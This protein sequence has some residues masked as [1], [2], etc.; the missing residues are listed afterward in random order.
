MATQ[1]TL[2]PSPTP[3]DIEMTEDEFSNS[4]RDLISWFAVFGPEANS[5]AR[6]MQDNAAIAASAVASLANLEWVSGT[7]YAAGNVR[8]SKIDFL[9]YRRKTNGAGTTDPRNDP[10]NWSV[11]VS[12]TQGGADTT[13]SASNIT[14]TSTNGRLQSISMTAA[15][16]KVTLPAATALEKGIPIFVFKNAGAYRFAIVNNSGVFLGYVDPG[17]VVSAGCSDTS[18]AAGVWAIIGSVGKLY[19]DNTQETVNAVVSHHICCAMLTATKAVVGYRNYSTGFLEAVI[20]NYGSASGTPIVLNSESS[21]NISITAQSASQAT[22][23]YSPVSNATIKGYVLDISS[24]TITP[25]SVQTIHTSANVSFKATSITTI[26]TTKLL[27]AYLGGVNSL[28]ERII[29][30]SGTTLTP[31][32][33]VQADSG[34]ATTTQYV[35]VKGL[36]NTK[37][38]VSYLSDTGIA[39]RLQAITGSTPSATGSVLSLLLPGSLMLAQFGFCVMSASRLVII[40]SIDRTRGDVMVFLVDIS[41]NTPVLLY[42][43]NLTIDF[44]RTETQI[45]AAKI[46]TN[47]VYMTYT[48]AYSGGVDSLIITV[49]SD[50]RILFSDVTENVLF[51]N[52][53][54]PNGTISN[55]FPDCEPLDS[56]HVLQLSRNAAGNLISKTLEIAPQ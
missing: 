54:L 27:I 53:N 20:V 11:Q 31:S 40:K 36:T 17:Q 38:V 5:I 2:P 7:T 29:D 43:K 28:R 22:I 51:S 25:G 21:E 52:I 56:S 45:S 13:S 26:T 50:D 9:P 30:I 4:M 33:E 19:S 42:S 32:S 34:V 14:L 1:L 12:T 8:Y 3:N 6:E 44:S 47:R 18:T 49:T 46:D 48:S 10:A 37:A 23:V 15:G 35:H 41:G 16:R 55:S 39:I 24:S